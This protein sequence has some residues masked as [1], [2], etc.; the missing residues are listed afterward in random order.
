MELAWVIGKDEGEEV[1][2][3]LPEG[4]FENAHDVNPFKGAFVV[5]PEGFTV[6]RVDAKDESEPMFAA[7]AEAGPTDR[8]AQG[9]RGALD[10]RFFANLAYHARCD[11]FIVADFSAEAVVLAEVL[12][13]AA[14]VAVDEEDVLGVRRHDVAESC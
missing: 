3:A 10:T 1:A 6:E 12:I 8:T 7:F 14:F 11:V 5:F 4:E 9:H 2:V 13:A